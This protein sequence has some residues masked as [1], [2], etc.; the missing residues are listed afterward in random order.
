[1]DSS[2][3]LSKQPAR[4]GPVTLLVDSCWVLIKWVFVLGLVCAVGGGYFY[5]QRLGEKIRSTF[6]Q[7]FAEH[8]PDLVVKVGSARLKEGGGIIVR[9]LSIQDPR[10]AAPWNELISIDEIF[11]QCATEVPDLL[12]GEIDVKQIILRRLVVRQIVL[13]DGTVSTANL[14]PLPK[15]SDRPPPVDIVDGTIYLCS[16]NETSSQECTLHEIQLTLVP[17]PGLSGNESVPLAP[18]TEDSQ[19]A[20]D[21]RGHLSSEHFQNLE[22]EGL[23]YPGMK[24][25]VFHGSIDDL[26]VTDRLLSLL[27]LDLA[28]RLDSIGSLTGRAQIAYTISREEGQGGSALQF[29][30][31]GQLSQGRIVS[32]RWGYPIDNIEATF[33][34]SNTGLRIDSMTARSG[35]ATL[36]LTLQSDLQTPSRWSIDGEVQ[37]LSLDSR[38]ASSLPE[39]IASVWP[40]FQPSGTIDA[41]FRITGLGENFEPEITADLRGVSFTYHRFPY[42]LEGA[43]GTMRFAEGTIDV[44]LNAMAGSQSVQIEGEI[45]DP[46]DR[47]YGQIEFQTA[48][49]LPVDDR[50]VAALNL[51]GQQVIRSFAARGMITASGRFV[52]DPEP[53]TPM[54][55]HIMIG[56]DRC[57][58]RYDR[59]A[60]PIDNVQ[61]TIE[62]RDGWWQFRDF[63]GRNDS[64]TITCQGDWT[65]LEEGGGLLALDIV[66][67]DV[68]LEDELRDA[69]PGE[70]QRLWLDLR[71]RGT[72]DHLHVGLSYSSASHDL[73]LDVRGQ[74]WPALQRIEGRSI[75]IEPACFPYAMND[76]TGSFHFFDGR[77]E[78][79]EIRASHGPVQMA[80]AGLWESLAEGGWQFTLSPFSVD[81]IVPDREVL[82]ALPPQLGAALEN[83]GV[84]EPMNVAGSI[85][86]TK[87]RDPA[88]PINASWE[89]G[90]DVEDARIECAIPVEHLFG[91][92]TLRG[93]QIDGNLYCRGEL[94]VDSLILHDIQFTEVQGPFWIDNE[95]V[96]LGSWANVPSEGT[97][98]RQVVARA[99]GGAVTLDARFG[100]T[101]DQFVLRTSVSAA[102]LPTIIRD[103][104]ATSGEIRGK[105]FASLDLQGSRQGVHTLR[106]TGQ[107]R[108][109]DADIY[110]LPLVLALLKIITANPLDDTAFTTSDID[111]HLEGDHIYLDQIVLGGDALTLK[112]TGEMNF[113]RDVN[114]DFY[115]IVGRDGFA[116]P[117]IRPLLGHASRQFLE[118]HVTGPL[119]DPQV[120]HEILPGVTETLQQLFPEEIRRLGEGVL[121]LQPTGVFGGGNPFSRRE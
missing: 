113:D 117:F 116:I 115:T 61:G 9:D 78:L 87:G 4:R 1:M 112:G 96:L 107:V 56:I 98:P 7:K 48:G 70:M 80:T 47:A 79:E 46:T 73:D 81:R 37:G 62:I 44:D 88:G 119:D 99:V 103:L 16:G 50:L 110:N 72:L 74:K 23:L 51:K 93:Q 49:P 45:H 36:Q 11:L 65:P 15:L 25:F 90:F 27:P 2:L 84:S 54:R 102:D 64:A 21:V 14:L 109:R 55:R 71:P 32:S 3:P 69:L 111:F 6:E 30:V 67:T 101:D 13:A 85:E 31:T 58:L 8:Y 60:Y 100:L 29:D 20:M 95:K 40:R 104:H 105:A 76:L 63:R 83:L 17:R 41:H 33:R 22:V 121:P 28:R 108:L 12:R 59:F 75:S 26:L 18:S 39:S 35:Q 106:G 19:H 94:D 92:V 52:R 10:L 120:Q 38:L 91:H 68:P 57:S 118:I 97:V 77:L 43:T 86:F 53:G 24:G 34:C 82:A 5:Y 89:L 66:A 42:R 114:L